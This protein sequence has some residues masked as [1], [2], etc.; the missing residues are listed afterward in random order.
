MQV[1]IA[2]WGDNLSK[3][4]RY[5]LTHL[6]LFN[7]FCAN[8]KPPHPPNKLPACRYV[9]SW[10][11]FGE[12]GLETIHCTG[13]SQFWPSDSFYQ[14]PILTD[15]SIS[16]RFWLQ[17]SNT[18]SPQIFVTPFKSL[19]NNTSQQKWQHFIT[20]Q[21]KCQG[22]IISKSLF[23]SFSFQNPIPSFFLRPS[24]PPLGTLPSRAR[25]PSRSKGPRNRNELS[26]PQRDEGREGVGGSW[27]F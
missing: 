21:Q 9:Q 11:V 10:N 20:Y 13:S 5:L 22:P 7:F 12:G 15:D 14:V 17:V 2:W 18:T 6:N 24:V 26:G 25:S 19:K 1:V 3:F 27:R 8:C 16:H 4:L 23:L